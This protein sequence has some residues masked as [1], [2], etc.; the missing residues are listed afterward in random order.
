MNY[1]SSFSNTEFEA[2]LEL[3]Y[4][5]VQ[6]LEGIEFEDGRI[7]DVELLAYKLYSHAI[8][9]YWLYQGTRA[10]VPKSAGGTNFV[11]N[12]SIIVLTRAALET[13][14]SFYEVFIEPKNDD[15]FEFAYCLWHL[16][17]KVMLEDYEP[18]V[19]TPEEKLEKIRIEIKE[20]RD[21]IKIT[22]AYESH[23][24]KQQ[25][26]ILKGKDFRDRYDI[27]SS[28]GLSPNFIRMVYKYYSGF[29]HSDGYTSG[30]LF[31][32]E[33]IHQQRNFAEFHLNMLMILVSKFILNFTEK[34]KQSS[35]LLDLN[36]GVHS[37]AY[38]W[39]EV[40]ARFD[41]FVP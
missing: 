26:Q 12:A 21:R 37:I 23:T 29:V 40:G 2:L 24:E 4:E 8:S 36:P 20:L 14:L 18:I 1:K 3:M 11:D 7:P 13:Y 34:F 16:S 41:N 27:A 10:H 35:Y 30:Q 17:G 9:S 22:K 38:T 6:S 39:S 28:A 25:P 5:V 32:A 19:E 15:D 33:T 31:S